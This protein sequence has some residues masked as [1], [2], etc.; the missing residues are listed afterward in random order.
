M[1]MEANDYY[2]YSKLKWTVLVGIMES[3]LL[4]LQGTF[5]MP[6][7]C[8]SYACCQPTLMSRVSQQS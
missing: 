3:I 2:L 6:H 1:E 5:L 4:G 8:V 7:G